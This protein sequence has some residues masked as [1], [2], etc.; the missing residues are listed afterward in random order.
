MR[1]RAALGLSENSDAMIVVVS[2][3]SGKI[4]I[5][6]NGK[7]IPGLN[8]DTLRRRLQE[9]FGIAAPKSGRLPS[10]ALP[11]R[12]PFSRR[13]TAEAELPAGTGGPP[14]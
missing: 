3:E 8:E 9:T 11:T 2:E 10:L 4:T 12:L 14:P 1:H 5:A 7:L 13:R 6:T